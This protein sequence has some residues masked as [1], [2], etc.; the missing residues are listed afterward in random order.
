MTGAIPLPLPGVKKD[1]AAPEQPK[2]ANSNKAGG[3]LPGPIRMKRDD[4]EFLAAALEILEQPASPIRISM[5]WFICLATFAALVWSWFGSLDIHAIAQGRI[6]PSGRSKVIQPVEAGRVVSIM[7]DNGS[8]VNVGDTLLELDPTDAAADSDI[9]QIEMEN[10]FAEMARRR[11]TI[12]AIEVADLRVFPLA[13]GIS[14]RDHIREREQLTFE[15][16]ISQ[17]VAATRGID[18]QIDEKKAQILRFQASILERERLTAV[19][20]E[21]VQARK[22]LL[23]RDAGSRAQVIDAIQELQRE[24]AVLASERG[25]VDELVASIASLQAKRQENVAQARADQRNKLSEAERRADKAVQDEIK[26]RSRK[27]RTRLTSPIAGTVT[28]LAVNTI[29]QVVSPAQALLTVVPLD[30]RLE[31]EAMILNKDIG[32]VYPGQEVIIKIEAFPFTRFGSINGKVLR[33][34]DDAVDEREAGNLADPATAAKGTNNSAL[35]A[36]PRV[37]NLVFPATISLEKGSVKI[38]EKDIPL[39]PGMTVTVEVKTGERRVLD[40]VLSPLREVGS[41]AARER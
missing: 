6:Q 15:T 1:Q 23:T 40:Y 18:A 12:A 20:D 16:D 3:Q 4:Q 14:L 30:S 35:S 31:V 29:G 22:L 32:F 13:F 41:E 33:V 5:I 7:V 24:K 8:R 39:T 10:A 19:Q 38:G 27:N 9:M 11:A 25:Q 36:T 28:Q 37:Q 21:R 34:S 2:P 17:L 26:A